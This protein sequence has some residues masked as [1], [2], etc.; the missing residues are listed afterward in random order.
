MSTFLQ[1]GVL[2]SSFRCCSSKV[3][4]NKRMLWQIRKESSDFEANR[5]SDRDANTG[6]VLFASV[7]SVYIRADVAS[8]VDANIESVSAC[9]RDVD[10]DINRER[11]ALVRSD[12]GD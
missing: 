12:S 4:T 10:G 2:R 1:Y 3:Q 11:S 8:H 6:A 9:D 7:G 5:E